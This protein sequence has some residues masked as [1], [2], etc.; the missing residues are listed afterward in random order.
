MRKQDNSF[1]MTVRSALKGREIPILVLD[2]RWH[3]LF[4]K[5]EKPEDIVQLEEQLNEHLKNQG[6]L[7]NEIK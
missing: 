5:G 1:E 3:T 6:R 7:V 4:P 2:A